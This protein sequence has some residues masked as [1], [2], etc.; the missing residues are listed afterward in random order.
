MHYGQTKPKMDPE[1]LRMLIKYKTFLDLVEGIDTSAD[2][3][4]NQAADDENKIP[5]SSADPTNIEYVKVHS[6]LVSLQFFS[7]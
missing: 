7:R 5:P 3:Q 1:K 2:E 6:E 4:S